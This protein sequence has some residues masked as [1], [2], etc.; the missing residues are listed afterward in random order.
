M[1]RLEGKVAL[2]TG[3]ANGQGA[4]EARLFAAEG[5][6]VVLTDIDD[7]KGREVAEDIVT[8]GGGAIYMHLDVAE[9]VDWKLA[10]ATAQG[11]FGGLHCLVNN[12]GVVPRTTLSETTLETLQQTLAIN[13]V[14]PMIG[15]KLGAPVI[16][17]SG[18]GTIINV[19]SAAGMI[20]H[21]DAAYTASKWG[22]RGV[23]KTAAVEYAPWNIRVNS[24]HP[25]QIEGTALFANASPDLAH[26]LRAS[27]P[28]QRAGKPGECAN[29]VL[30]LASDESTFITGAEIP[31]DGGY[32]SGATMW[33]RQQSKRQM[34]GD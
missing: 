18:G 19:S 16:R 4:A 5:A 24:I 21:Y 29:L 25:G 11:T 30:Y 17:N 27:I 15:M 10:V 20:A 8:S 6:S 22:L 23:T 33:M 31:I 3:A 32:S 14:G 26:S 2:I 28:M 12:A 1:K 9:E 34:T 13:L 7:K